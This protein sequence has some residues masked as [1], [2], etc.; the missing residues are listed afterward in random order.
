MVVV[1][2]GWG[3][4]AFL[5]GF[6]SQTVQPL[7]D[8][9]FWSDPVCS[10]LCTIVR[11]QGVITV[12]FSWKATWLLFKRLFYYAG[13]SSIIRAWCQILR[14]IS[15]ILLLFQLVSQSSEGDH[16]LL[17]VQPQ[18]NKITSLPRCHGLPQN[19]PNIWAAPFFL[20]KISARIKILI[21][22]WIYKPFP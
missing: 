20:I 11:H 12:R 7:R 15:R 14:D 10:L 2:G 17:S 8:R 9:K 6:P 22:T 13:T 5:V 19:A 16:D 3:R 4:G 21:N 1:G 18:N